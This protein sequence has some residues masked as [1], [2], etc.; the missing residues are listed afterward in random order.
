VAGLQALGPGATPLV[1]AGRPRNIL[2][3]RPPWGDALGQEGHV[4][5][6]AQKARD[7]VKLQRATQI[8]DNKRHKKV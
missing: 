5:I 1:S 6:L 2:S 7:F 3:P 4:F 8:K